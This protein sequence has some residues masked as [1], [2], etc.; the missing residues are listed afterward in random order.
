VKNRK[1]ILLTIILLIVLAALGEAMRRQIPP[2]LDLPFN[3]QSTVLAAEF[4]KGPDEVNAVFGTEHRYADALK[5]VQY[6]DFV[7]IPCYVAVFVLLGLALREYDL[8]AAR[9]VAWTT[10]ALAVAAGVLDVAENL[11]ILNTGA[12]PSAIGSN[13][14]WFSIP[15][16]IVVFA[17]MLIQSAVLFFWPGLK[18]AWRLGAVVV[19]V[20]FLFAGA[21]GV[22][23]ASLVSVQDIEFSARWMA[24][25]FTGLLI[26]LVAIYL[27]GGRRKRT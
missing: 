7:F 6:L 4:V 1:H 16:W 26:F 20:M 5:R 19:G 10:V 14:R 12:N 15:K 21:S 8:P 23:F 9:Q 13:V 24:Y 11:A 25:A 17:L 2:R 22:L 3:T 18:L 27:R